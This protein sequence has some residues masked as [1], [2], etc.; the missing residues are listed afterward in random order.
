[1]KTLLKEYTSFVEGTTPPSYEC[2]YQGHCNYVFT[3]SSGRALAF[4]RLSKY[5]LG[6]GDS[7]NSDKYLLLAR[8]YI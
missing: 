8:D 5:Y 4:W 3:G 2:I 1:M 7:S 6:L